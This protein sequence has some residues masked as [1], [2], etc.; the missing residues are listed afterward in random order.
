VTRS[1]ACAMPLALYAAA[2]ELSDFGGLQSSL[3]LRIAQLSG[4]V[5][6]GLFTDVTLA[7]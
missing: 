7:V 1:I 4:T 6:T 5:G 2:D 3:H